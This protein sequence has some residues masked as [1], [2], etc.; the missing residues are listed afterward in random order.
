[1]SPWVPFPRLMRGIF[2]V[3]LAGSV[4]WSAQSRAAPYR[5]NSDD[6]VLE[7]VPA[8]T[9]RPSAAPDLPQALQAARSYIEQARV[10]GDPRWLGYAEGVLSPWRAMPEPPPALRLLWATLAQSQHRF[11]EALTDLDAL[12]QQDPE[13]PQAWL[14]RA[15]LLRVQGRYA[16]AAHSCEALVGRSADFIAALCVTAVRGLSGQLDLAIQQL[17]ELE[18]LRNQQ[19]P[20]IQAWHAV[21]LGEA[22]ARAGDEVGAEKAWRAG[23]LIAPEDLQL[24]LALADLLLDQRRAD[25]VLNLLACHSQAEALVLRQVLA[26]KILGKT[27]IRLKE[28]LAE[29]YASAHRRGEALHLREEALFLLRIAEQPA[30]AL[31]IAQKNWA[32]QRE[33]ADSLLLARAAAAQPEALRLLREWIQST[34]YEDAR[35]RQGLEGPP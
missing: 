24:R 23:L 17:R 27:G 28:Q 26:Q 13:Q 7:R 4:G 30:Q 32:S 20:S 15:T 5:P 1:M 3:A 16:E 10:D 11:S 35:L 18:A 33:P 14:T 21:E 6:E 8:I 2:L 25:E 29:G 19:P 34:G 12:L 31:V 9:V 22:L